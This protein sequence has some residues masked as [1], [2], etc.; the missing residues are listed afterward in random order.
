M[1]RCKH[2]WR[3]TR[4]QSDHDGSSAPR[5][6]AARRPQTADVLGIPARLP[7]RTVGCVERLSALCRALYTGR[8]RDRGRPSRGVAGHHGPHRRRYG[9]AAHEIKSGAGTRTSVSKEDGW[10]IDGARMAQWLVSGLLSAGATILLALGYQSCQRTRA[11]E[12]VA[13]L[14]GASYAPRVF[15]RGKVKP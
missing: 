11:F 15:I 5:S 13:C 1:C 12:H 8:M 9:R 14:P 3:S 7:L 2:S 4:G 6:A 10:D